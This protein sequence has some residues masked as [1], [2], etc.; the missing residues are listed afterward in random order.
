TRLTALAH[1]AGA[2]VT[3]ILVMELSRKG[4]IANAL[5]A[6][7]GRR[8]RIILSDTLL[9]QYT[10]E[11][12]E[13]ILAHELGH[14][15]RHDIGRLLA[16]R[17]AVVVSVLYITSLSLEGSVSALG[18]KGAAD[19]AGL[20]LL[21]LYLGILGFL[22]LPAGNAYSRRREAAADRFA[23]KLT[24]NPAAFVSAMTKLCE[25]NLSEARPAPWAEFLFHTHPSYHKRIELA[26]EYEQPRDPQAGLTP[27]A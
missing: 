8:R 6:G 12:V 3:D 23:L 5:L 14:Q 24:A 11:E 19:V 22:S 10:P 13:V 2:R 27:S 16:L 7:M 4:N 9:S 26:A 15:L 1:K 20:P 17:G 18:L 21:I 25:Q